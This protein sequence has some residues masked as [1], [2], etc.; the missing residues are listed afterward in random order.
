MNEPHGSHLSFP[1]R[2]GLDGRTA[3][4]DSVEQHVREELIQL[5]L[6]NAGERAFLPEFGGDVR[7]LVFAG[8]DDTTT[9]VTKALITRALSRW[10]GHRLSLEEL[11]VSTEGERI[12]V[13][14]RYR[15]AETGE[16]R[17]MRFERERA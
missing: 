7:R 17:I 5:L 15:L 3:R 14:I 6:T 16:S 9:G 12:D 11:Q 4:V 2:I 8:A 1:F 13:T 10:L